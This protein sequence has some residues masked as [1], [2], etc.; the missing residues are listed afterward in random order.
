MILH[1][2]W[3]AGS[4]D[5]INFRK[6]IYQFVFGNSAINLIILHVQDRQVL[7]SHQDARH[8]LAALV[9]QLVGGDDESADLGFAQGFAQFNDADIRDLVTTKIQVVNIL[10]CMLL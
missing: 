2:V 8:L 9:R 6:C 3:F 5:Y 7:V 4:N 1:C 10:F